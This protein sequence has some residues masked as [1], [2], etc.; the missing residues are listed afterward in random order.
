MKA[1]TSNKSTIVVSKV[2]NKTSNAT[3]TNSKSNS[4]DVIKPKTLNI[5]L[6][7]NSIQLGSKDSLSTTI[8]P[9]FHGI[10]NDEED[11]YFHTQFTKNNND[12]LNRWILNIYFSFIII[13]ILILFCMGIIL[14]AYI[15]DIEFKH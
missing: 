2:I 6:V 8:P 14:V 11:Y 12:R 13:S 10:D 5:S 7:T 3:N 4:T 15:K 9:Q 1:S